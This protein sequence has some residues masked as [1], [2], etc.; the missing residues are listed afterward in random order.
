MLRTLEKKWGGFFKWHESRV[1]HRRMAENALVCIFRFPN[2]CPLAQ[3]LPA[4]SLTTRGCCAQSVGLHVRSKP[5][6]VTILAADRPRSSSMI[7]TSLQP[8]EIASPTATSG[9]KA[10]IATAPFGHPVVRLQVPAPKMLKC[11]FL[12]MLTV[13]QSGRQ[14]AC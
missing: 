11:V 12:F 6:R 1:N 2:K 5:V 14:S 7:S 9:M 3:P 10:G 4:D 8:R 13:I